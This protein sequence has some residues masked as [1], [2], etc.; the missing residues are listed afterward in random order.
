M[1]GNLYIKV[2]KDTTTIAQS[3]A[4]NH[5]IKAKNWS[6]FITFDKDDPASCVLVINVP[7]ANL[8]V[9]D[10]NDRKKLGGKKE[11]TNKISESQRSKVKK[12]MLAKG[13]LNASA[14]KEISF[15]QSKGCKA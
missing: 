14:H 1:G 3:Q 10:P 2:Y 13:Q 6:G 8:V 9:D 12:N 7:V 11:F 5:L 15:E 4:H